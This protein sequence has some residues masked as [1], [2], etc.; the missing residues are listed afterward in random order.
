MRFEYRSRRVPRHDRTNTIKLALDHARE[1]GVVVLARVGEASDCRGRE[2]CPLNAAANNRTSLQAEHAQA[3]VLSHSK[4]NNRMGFVV[5]NISRTRMVRI[6]VAGVGK[7][8]MRR[9]S[10]ADG[11]R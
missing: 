10:L 9:L 7:A 4:I 5:R 11:N 1:R 6:G 8:R 2:V 3:D